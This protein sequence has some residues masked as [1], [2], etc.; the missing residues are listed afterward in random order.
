MDFDLEE[1][2]EW[3]REIRPDIIEIGADNYHKKLPEPA[4]SKVEELLTRLREI[5]PEVKEKEGLERLK[6]GSNVK[7][8][9]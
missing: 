3:M 8:S 9:I 2:V 6:G 5:C 1:M 7:A 4:W